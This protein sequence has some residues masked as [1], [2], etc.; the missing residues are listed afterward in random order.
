MLLG[1]YIYQYVNPDLVFIL[2]IFIDLFV[3]MP[4]LRTVPETLKKE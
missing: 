4:I 1:G 3:R 2:P